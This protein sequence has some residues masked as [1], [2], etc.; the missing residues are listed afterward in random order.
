VNSTGTAPDEQ[1]GED[2]AAST[3]PEQRADEP[4][5]FGIEVVDVALDRQVNCRH[6]FEPQYCPFG[7]G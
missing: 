7:C 3:E 5:D 2:G 6:G 4:V 1:P